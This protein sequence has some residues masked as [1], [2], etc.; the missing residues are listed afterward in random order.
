MTNKNRQ[1]GHITPKNRNKIIGYSII[2]TIIYFACFVLLKTHPFEDWWLWPFFDDMIGV[3]MAAGAIAI[4]TGIILVVQSVIESERDKKQKVFDKKLALYSGIIE[5]MEG[6]YRLKE[7]EEVP[8]IDDQERTDLF[9]TQLKVALLAK[10]K[11]FRSYS[12]LINDIADDEGVI[13]EE[14]TKLLLDFIVDARSDL[15]VQE[16]M[17][18]EDQKSFNES[19]EI[20]EKAAGNIQKT[21]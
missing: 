6:L 17:S 16:E 8:L 15:D 18:P 10:P 7:G 4:I 21:G 5:Q 3:F 19:L 1:S 20:A 14:A 12:Q 9:F 11:T 13:K 2:I